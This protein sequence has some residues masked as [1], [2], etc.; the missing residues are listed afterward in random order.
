MFFEK[1]TYI[2]FY[3]MARISSVILRT[4]TGKVGNIVMRYTRGRTILCAIP[5]ENKS[6]TP[7]QKSQRNGFGEVSKISRSLTNLIDIGFART[8]KGTKR[9]HFTSKNTSLMRYAR[10]GNYY[11]YELPPITN[12]CLAMSDDE[13]TGRIYSAVGGYDLNTRFGWGDDKQVEA[14]LIFR[15]DFEVGDVIY[16]F[17]LYSYVEMDEFYEMV[18]VFKKE[19]SAE[20][21][22]A[23]EVK[24][25]FMVNKV[26][27]P[28]L[29]TF[30]DLPVGHENLEILGTV[31]VANEED[32]STSYIYPI[33]D[34]PY[35]FTVAEQTVGTDSKMTL[36]D[37]NA[38]DFAREFDGKLAGS[39]MVCWVDPTYRLPDFPFKDYLKDSSGK[40]EG[41]IFDPPLGKGFIDP[42]SGYDGYRISMMLEEEEIIR[43]L[44]AKVPMLAE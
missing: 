44:G 4:G 1:K 8:E 18:N 3:F 5:I 7:L 32:R 43:F 12:M 34:M 6:N 42:F 10:E 9:N 22:E 17:L 30:K 16:L 14:S 40:V 11:D 15:R 19:L 20:D 21:I 13:F 26:S 31:I 37:R 33:P 27:M 39:V 28:D 41:I 2:I 24:N 35:M 23:L 29:D 25:K 38:A 36:R